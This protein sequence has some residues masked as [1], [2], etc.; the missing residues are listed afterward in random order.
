MT[1]YPAILSLSNATECFT[2][3]VRWRA[4]G[5]LNGSSIQDALN[6]ISDS[7]KTQSWTLRVITHIHGKDYSSL[8]RVQHISSSREIFLNAQSPIPLEDLPF[9]ERFMVGTFNLSAK[10]PKTEYA[11]APPLYPWLTFSQARPRLLS[12]PSLW[13]RLRLFLL[14]ILPARWNISLF[15]RSLTLLSVL[16]AHSLAFAVTQCTPPKTPNDLQFSKAEILYVN[17]QE[18]MVT[19]KHDGFTLLELPG[20]TGIYQITDDSLLQNMRIGAKGWVALI[21]RKT[22]LALAQWQPEGCFSEVLS[23]N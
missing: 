15:I 20:G 9:A 19:I 10:P 4:T 6:L 2:F 1:S 17:A 5:V 21:R 14:T 18:G 16:S 12:I 13:P 3:P 23:K 11:L 22:H 8:V 7:S